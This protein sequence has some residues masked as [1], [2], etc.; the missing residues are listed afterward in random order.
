MNIV[1][2]VPLLEKTL[3]YIEHHPEDW[4]QHV[5]GYRYVPAAVGVDELSEH[6]MARCNTV[7]CFAGNCVLLAG[8]EFISASHPAVRVDGRVYGNAGLAAEDLLGL[9]LQQADRL[10]RG[11]NDLPAL[12]GIVAELVAQAESGGDE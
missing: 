4:D 11:Y 12:R 2:N 6:S 9:T 5:W 8:G 1:L 10:F 3:D 7:C